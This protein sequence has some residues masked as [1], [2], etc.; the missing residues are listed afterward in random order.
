MRP[1]HWYF[2]YRWDCVLCSKSEETRE[3]RYTPRPEDPADRC[4]YEEG[5]CESHFL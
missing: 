5:A 3:R 1:P 2:I 4:D